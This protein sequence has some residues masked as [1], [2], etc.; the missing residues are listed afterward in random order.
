VTGNDLTWPQVTGSD[1]KV[2]RKWRHFTG[3]HHEVAVEGRKLVYCTFH[4]LQGC[5]SQEEAVTWQE[6]TSRDLRWP[7]VTWSWCQLTGSHLEEAVESQTRVYCKFHFLQGFSSQEEPLTRQEMTSHDL[8]RTEMTRKWCPL[9]GSH[10]EVAVEGQKLHILYFLT[11][12]KAVARGGSSHVTGNNVTWPQVTESDPEK[13]SFDRN[14]PG[15]GC[16]RPKTGVYCTFHFLHGCSSQEEA[17]TWLEMTSR[18]LRW[19]KVTWKW[20]QLSG[21]HLEAAV[22]VRRLACTLRF[23]CYKAVARRRTQSRDRKWCHMTSGDRKWAG[24]DVIWPEVTWK[25]LWKAENWRILNISLRT[26]L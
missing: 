1:P 16:G 14:S 8:R 18:D 24:I 7:E 22:E 23:P 17:V 9:T 26:R 4:L 15:S 6:M 20:R 3:S 2:T 11:S 21:S 10:L 25:W 19:P 5:S 13:T 12:C